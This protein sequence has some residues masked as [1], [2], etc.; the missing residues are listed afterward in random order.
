[1]EKGNRNFT[2]Y[3]ILGVGTTFAMGESTAAAL[4]KCDL[5][6]MLRVPMILSGFRSLVFF[7][8]N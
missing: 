2:I 4:N 6:G 3:G 7:F 5:F 1:V 8:N